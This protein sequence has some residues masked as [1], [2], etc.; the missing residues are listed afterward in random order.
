M[1]FSGTQ[2]SS[3]TLTQGW[4]NKLKEDMALPSNGCFL[5]ITSHIITA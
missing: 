4:K 5:D 2:V 1:K 3:L